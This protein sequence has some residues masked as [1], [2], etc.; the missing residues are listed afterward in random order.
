MGPCEGLTA[1]DA[2]A[3]RA[4][5]RHRVSVAVPPPEGAYTAVTAKLFL[6]PL[7]HDDP[8]SLFDRFDC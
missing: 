6:R 1:L 8:G 3:L 4:V 7:T 2:S 5:N